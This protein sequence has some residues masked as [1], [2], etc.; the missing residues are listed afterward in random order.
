[1]EHNVEKEKLVAIPDSGGYAAFFCRCASI[2]GF[3]TPASAFELKCSSCGATYTYGDKETGVSK[4]G[5][6]IVKEK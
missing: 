5:H 1:V 3:V 2:L 4:S 6:I